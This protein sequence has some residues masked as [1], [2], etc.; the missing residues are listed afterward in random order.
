[1]ERAQK[2]GAEIAGDT[3]RFVGKY[4]PKQKKHPVKHKRIQC[5][6]CGDGITGR[7]APEGDLPSGTGAG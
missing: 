7:D 5:F 4:S 1:M 2:S 6:F 3:V